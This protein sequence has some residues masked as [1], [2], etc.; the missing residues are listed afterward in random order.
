MLRLFKR[1]DRPRRHC[2]SRDIHLHLFYFH[3]LHH[4]LLPMPW[5]I[6]QPPRRKS[7]TNTANHRQHAHPPEILPAN[8]TCN[9][10]TTSPKNLRI[11]P[12]ST[13]LVPV[14]AGPSDLLLPTPIQ[15]LFCM[16]QRLLPHP[17]PL[18]PQLFPRYIPVRHPPHRPPLTHRPLQQHQ[19]QPPPIPPMRHLPH[20]ILRQL[21]APPRNRKLH[22]PPHELPQLYPPS[23]LQRPQSDPP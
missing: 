8:C 9:N 12:A 17:R 16:S 1:K 21:P 11:L 18:L 15:G 4:Q 2:G 23:N 20:L 6:P 19:K 7:Q 14:P 5:S 3:H 22:A 10:I 13:L